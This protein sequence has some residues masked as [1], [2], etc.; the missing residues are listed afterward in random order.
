MRANSVSLNFPIFSRDRRSLREVVGRLN[1]KSRFN[2]TEGK[3]AVVEGIKNISLSL[4]G[5]DRLALV[6]PN[7]AGKTTLLQVLA[8]IYFPSNGTVQRS[9]TL[10][11][12]LGMGMGLDMDA[13]GMEN[14]YIAHYLHGFRNHQIRGLVDEIVDFC[15][16]DEFINMPVRTYSAGMRTR[17][18]F[19]ISTSFV[20]DVLLIDEVFGAGDKRFFEKSQ[21]RMETLMKKSRILVFASHNDSLLKTFCNKAMLMLDGEQVE[22]GGVDEVLCA[23][24]ETIN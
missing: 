6:G 18:A 5:G 10:T 1:R 16:L 4:E 17:L 12:L 3:S 7:G 24:E 11:T 15:E 21:K 8:G 2:M 23:Y 14:I 13:S 19:A 22:V 20:P 9:G